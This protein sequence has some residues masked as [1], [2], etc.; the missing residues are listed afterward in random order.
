MQAVLRAPLT[1]FSVLATQVKIE[2]CR[3]LEETKCAGSC[4]HTCKIPTQ[5]FMQE[6]MG[7]PLYME[8]NLEDFS[9]EVRSSTP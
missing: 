8:P 4:M 2:K 3:F 9:C 6:H 7:V 5:A 1:R